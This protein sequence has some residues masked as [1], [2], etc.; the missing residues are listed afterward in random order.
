MKWK[1]RRRKSIITLPSSTAHISHESN[2]AVKYLIPPIDYLKP[3]LFNI[4]MSVIS[5]TILILICESFVKLNS[6]KFR[7]NSSHQNI[8]FDN[9]GILNV[10]HGFTLKIS[11][12][13]LLFFWLK[14]RCRDMPDP[15][16]FEISA[17]R[18]RIF[19]NS[20][21]LSSKIVVTFY[22][23]CTTIFHYA[24]HPLL[25]IANIKFRFRVF[26]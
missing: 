1:K 14:E 9:V 8:R 13:N 19:Y 25:K 6:S 22:F 23:D 21:L 26:R 12:F 5:R 16:A 7:M 11:T 10:F 3:K 18:C 24:S 20:Q 4:K 15:N 17:T 2:E